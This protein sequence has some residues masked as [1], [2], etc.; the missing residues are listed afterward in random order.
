MKQ[1]CFLELIEWLST[2]DRRGRSGLELGSMNVNTLSLQWIL[3]ATVQRNAV[4]LCS[5]FTYCYQ[6]LHSLSVSMSIL[7]VT[8][9]FFFFSFFC[10][11]SDFTFIEVNE[12]FVTG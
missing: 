3:S 7:N 5:A 8:V 4:W 10:F 6:L 12:I 11:D 9:T 1:F 2:S